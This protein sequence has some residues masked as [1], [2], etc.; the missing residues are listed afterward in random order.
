MSTL[1][2]LRDYG[3]RLTIYCQTVS[4]QHC[5]NSWEP[6][7]DQLIQYFGYDFDPYAERGK[8]VGR[9]I[10]EK[11]GQRDVHTIW[12]PPADTPGIMRGMRSY[13]YGTPDPEMM[14]RLRAEG[15]EARRAIAAQVQEAQDN[16]KRRRVEK[17][18]REAI[19]SGRDLIGPPN[20][21]MKPRPKMTR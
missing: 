10:C 18:A 2:E 14:A 13:E 4:P 5:G 21:F 15:E 6:S 1:R 20:P 12:L 8:F 11:C 7:F 16:R 3:A 19:E 17:K 9:L